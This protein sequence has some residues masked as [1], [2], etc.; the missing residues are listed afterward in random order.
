MG[1]NFGIGDFAACHDRQDFR[2]KRS[3]IAQKHVGQNRR[4]AFLGRNSKQPPRLRII[5]RHSK[6]RAF[7][8]DL[9]HQ[10]G[11]ILAGIGAG[12][13]GHHRRGH[14]FGHFL[15]NSSAQ[16]AG[17]AVVQLGELRR[18]ARLKRKTAQ[19]GGAKAVDGLNAQ[20]AR[21]FNGA[22]KQLTRLG[23]RAGG[24]AALI[25]QFGKGCVQIGVRFH[26][27]FAQT[28]EQA[29]LHLGRCGFGVGQ[30]Q[31]VLRL[32]PGQQKPRHTVGQ[33]TGLA[34]TGVGRKPGGG[35]GGRGLNLPFRGVVAHHCDTSGATVS[36]PTVSG[37]ARSD[38]CHSP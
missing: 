10:R 16:Q 28:A 38:I 27:P 36:A 29:V 7:A 4:G 18:H 21:R 6:A 25:P 32:H 24:M 1:R 14:G 19:Q 37:K 31:Y 12:D 26:R 30:A 13:F 17:G 33:H 15:D 3:L 9:L 35:G 5:Q 20:A 11:E 22:G 2:Q 23:Q 34:R 8:C